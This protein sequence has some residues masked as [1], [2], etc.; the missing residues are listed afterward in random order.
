VVLDYTATGLSLKQHPIAFIR[1]NLSC[2]GVR[3]C[4]VLR[5]S[6]LAPNGEWIA[7]AG[8]VLVRQRPG[9]A[10]GVTFMTL[11]DETGIANIVVWRQVYQRDRRAASGKLVIV[12]GRVQ[13]EGEV[14]H[15][16]ASRLQPYRASPQETPPELPTQV[17]RNFR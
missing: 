13:R 6:A 1:E 3:P 8:L 5:D 9:T 10:E 2:K 4:G 17:S 11:E 16:I 7:V 12:R 14:V 15:V